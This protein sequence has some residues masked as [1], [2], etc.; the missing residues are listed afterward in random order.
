MSKEFQESVVKQLPRLR[1]FAMLL[2]RHAADAEDLVQT[3][4]ERMLK[5]ESYFEVGTNFSAW[6]Y[7]ILRNCHISVC[8][9]NKRRPVSLN[10]YTDAAVPPSSLLLSGNQ[11]NLVFTREVL[12]ALNTLSSEQ[13]EV[14]TLICAAELSYI[15]VAGLLE[16]SVGTVKSRLWRARAQMRTLLLGEPE[17]DVLT[18]NPTPPVWDE[19]VAV[20]C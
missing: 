10:E 19:P 18:S 20:A 6:S 4:A 9:K 5:Y 3:A 15:E 16:C 11:E 2:T 1:A 17:N 14:M 12:D 7:R 13:R 8:R